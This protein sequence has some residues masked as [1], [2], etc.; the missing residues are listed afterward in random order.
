V[1]IGDIGIVFLVLTLAAFVPGVFLALNDYS[2]ID[3][4]QPTTPPQTHQKII[5]IKRN[6]LGIKVISLF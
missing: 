6:K 4:F 2:Q 3:G 5:T 1:R